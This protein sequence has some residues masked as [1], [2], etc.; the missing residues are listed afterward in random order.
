MTPEQLAMVQRVSSGDMRGTVLRKGKS[1]GLR[2]R[3]LQMWLKEQGID[4]GPVDGKFG[5]RTQ[6][7]L[8][9]Y[10]KR[11]GITVDGKAGGET[12]GRIKAAIEGG[13][14][15][16][17]PRPDM[18]PAPLPA[19]MAAPPLPDAMAPPVGAVESAP[20]PDIQP[21]IMRGANSPLLDP[22]VQSYD[23]AAL[24]L[25][26]PPPVL[27]APD[28]G[29]APLPMMEPAGPDFNNPAMFGSGRGPGELSSGSFPGDPAK[30]A[31]SMNGVDMLRAA[32][33]AKIGQGDGL[34]A[35][36]MAAMQQRPDI[37]RALLAGTQR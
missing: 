7:G 10:Q 32:L 36:P 4:I 22:Q 2:V 17:H 25:P 12:F 26:A 11:A 13:Q 28:F 1:V 5:S 18:Q 35:D 8:R 34:V 24:A 20:L 9:E 21:D 3:V 33:L 23:P 27:Q 19:A 30:S 6:A 37:A 29:A 15:I 16:P 14:V 31:Q